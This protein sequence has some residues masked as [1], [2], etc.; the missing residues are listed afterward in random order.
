MIRTFDLFAGIGGFRIA[1][2]KIFKKNKIRNI[3]VGWS[4]IDKYCQ[5]TYI[6]NYNLDKTYFVDDIKQITAHDNIFCNQSNYDSIKKKNFIKKPNLKI[7]VELFKNTKQ[8][9]KKYKI[10]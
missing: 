5:K 8:I 4:E 9:D 6:S 2:D 1:S 7:T 3:S 10:N